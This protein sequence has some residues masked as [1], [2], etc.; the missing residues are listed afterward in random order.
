M[1]AVEYVVI[2]IVG[3]IVVI[4]LGYGWKKLSDAVAILFDRDD[5]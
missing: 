4:S 1:V 3:A 5:E 2:A